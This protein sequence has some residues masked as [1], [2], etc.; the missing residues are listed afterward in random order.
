M[1]GDGYVANMEFRNLSWASHLAGSRFPALAGWNK[2]IEQIWAVLND[3]SFK[4]FSE[5]SLRGAPVRPE[6]ESWFGKDGK[7]FGM[8]TVHHAA[9]SLRMPFRWTY[10]RAFE[11]NSVVDEDLQVRG[12]EGLYVCDMS[13][14][15]FS[16]AANP[17]RTLAALSLRLSERLETKL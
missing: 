5:F 14:M 12:A 7:G 3:V 11:P 4:I 1:D 9:C 10:D 15:P 17:V 2:S 6:N 13:V 8:G 16:S